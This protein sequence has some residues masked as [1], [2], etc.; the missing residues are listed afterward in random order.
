LTQRVPYGRKYGSVRKRTAR[1]SKN[2]GAVEELVLSQE[3][4][5]G[6][7]RTVRHFERKNDIIVNLTFPY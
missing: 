2:I 5:P 4:P 7:H 3:D 6:T 1:A